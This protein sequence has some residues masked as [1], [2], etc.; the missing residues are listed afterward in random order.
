[1]GEVLLRDALRNDNDTFYGKPAV[2]YGAV[3]FCLGM[4]L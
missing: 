3:G 1:M 4:A 2:P